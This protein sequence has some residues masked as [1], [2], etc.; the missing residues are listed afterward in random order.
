[1][2]TKTL[3]ENW[4]K[5]LEGDDP[6]GGDYADEEEEYEVSDDE[7][8]DDEE[9]EAYADDVAGYNEPADY[10]IERFGKHREKDAFE[11]K[12]VLTKL[13]LQEIIKDVILNQTKK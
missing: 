4:R 13:K 2:K 1:M 10:D 11:N 8:W 5:H 12:Q 3:F 7:R 6:G 9:D